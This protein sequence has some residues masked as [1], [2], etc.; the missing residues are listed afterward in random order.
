M[1]D[2]RDSNITEVRHSSHEDRANI[3]DLW[4]EIVVRKYSSELKVSILSI[5]C[6]FYETVIKN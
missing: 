1:R 3:K 4:Y 5:Y 6:I 2:S